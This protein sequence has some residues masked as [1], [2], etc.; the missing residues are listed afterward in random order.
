M[1][2]A[3]HPL[4]LSRHEPCCAAE[5]KL[6]VKRSPDWVADEGWLAPIGASLQACRPRLRRSRR[7]VEVGFVLLSLMQDMQQHRGLS[8]ALLDRQTAFRGELDAVTEKLQRSLVAVQDQF[9][10]RYAV[11]D[12]EPW[13]ALMSRWQALCNNWQM[14]DFA[15]NLAA[16]SELV[17]GVAE[18]L[19]TIA[20][21]HAE[22][23]GAGRTRIACEWPA[24]VEHLGMLR[25]IGLHLIARAA[26]SDD[27]QV[28]VPFKH[29]L[30]E[31]RSALASI[32]ADGYADPRLLERSEHV[33]ERVVALRNG[34]ATPRPQAY[35]LLMTRNIDAWFGAIRAGLRDD[36]GAALA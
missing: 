19:R 29:H 3:M 34:L 16:H 35:H 32:A 15:T 2:R 17:L 1:E 18:I 7:I 4:R 27:V 10:G 21:Q 24:L 13:Q 31:L 36:R 33:V 20:T 22:D 14:L 26:D 8:G 25:A 12:S 23:L 30:H 5:E 28:C 11:F 6:A 9:G